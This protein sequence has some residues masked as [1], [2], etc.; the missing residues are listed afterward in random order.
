MNPSQEVLGWSRGLRALLAQRGCS[1]RS[2]ERRLGWGAGYLSQLL[3]A[4]SPPEL[5]ARHLLAILDVLGE[6]PATFFA[7]LYDLAPRPTAGDGGP[8]GEE[9]APALDLDEIE[10]RIV[11]AIRREL[12][13]RGTPPPAGAGAKGLDATS[14]GRGGRPRR[15]A[16]RGQDAN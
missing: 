4:G 7:R 6:P 14:S 5:K 9:P 16:N 2:V 15:K 3:R 1:Q 12:D 8:R 10:R 13:R 11:A